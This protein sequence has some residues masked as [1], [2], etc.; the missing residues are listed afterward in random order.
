[1]NRGF[2]ALT[3]A[4][5]ILAAGSIDAGPAAAIIG[6]SETGQPY[7]FM[8]S[9][10]YD[11]PRADGHRCG[12][13]LVAPRW[14]LT[15]G[16]CANSP[17][18]ATAG[19]P[20]G[21]QVRVG[22]SAVDS[23]GELVTVDKFYRRHNKYD[24]AGEDLSLMRLRVPVKAQPVELSTSTPANGTAVRILGWG[25]T[26]TACFSDFQDARCYPRHL[27]QADTEV[28]PLSQCW[29]DDGSTLPLCIGQED[30]AVGAGNMDSGGPALIRAAG[31]WIL[32][33]TVIGPGIRGS[34]LPVM[35]ADVSENAG[36]ISGIINGT[37][38]PPDDVIPNMEGSAA[39]GDCRGAV[40]RTPAARPRDRALVLTNG[41]CV[42]S[43]RPAPGKALIDLPAE[44]EN[45][46]TIGD[47]AG[48]TKATSRATR[49]VYAT[50]TGTDIALYRLD[51]TYAQLT[52][53]GAKIFTLTTSPMR[54]GSRFW[55][56]RGSGRPACTVDAVVPHLREAGWQQENAVRYTLSEACTSE[57]GDSGS[58]LLSPDENTVMGINNTHNT[59]G[60]KCTEGNPCEIGV[61]GAVTVRQGHSYGQQ[62]HQIVACLDGHSMLDLSR[63]GCTLTGAPHA[64]PGSTR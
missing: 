1:M 59:D 27:R 30:P 34:D 46:V 15:A 10:Q 26:S 32:A 38:V 45:P 40:V 9:V 60:E 49:L 7:S 58:P 37:A 36:W 39:V 17:T 57:P 18:G 16:H 44:L 22:S 51:K 50:M 2:S 42:T 48:Y 14:V 21:W 24:P 53:A 62:I 47:S 41:H 3:L 20:R 31:R 11:S 28:M 6:G 63:S 54:R 52:A 61:R 8:V 13:V 23:G 56:A 55:L 19:T 35:Y 43:S 5:L 33:G 4:G 25:A 64:R 12:G 29:D